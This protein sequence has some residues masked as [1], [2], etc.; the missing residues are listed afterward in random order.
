MT[1]FDPLSYI[2]RPSTSGLTPVML[3]PSGMIAMTIDRPSSIGLN[4]PVAPT[5][6]PMLRS[7]SPYVKICSPMYPAAATAIEPSIISN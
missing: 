1:K 4:E 6:L 7:V 5:K 2:V 3:E